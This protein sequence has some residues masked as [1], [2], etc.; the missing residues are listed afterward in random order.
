[1]TRKTTAQ[2]RREVPAYDKAIRAVEQLLKSW[3]PSPHGLPLVA[4]LDPDTRVV[5]IV[6]HGTPRQ[7]N[8]A[9]REL[10]QWGFAG[11]SWTWEQ[12][13]DVRFLRKTVAR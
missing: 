7:A 5:S 11:G 1:M 10:F 9:D 6:L 3:P 12:H 2:W 4:H 8:D 13:G